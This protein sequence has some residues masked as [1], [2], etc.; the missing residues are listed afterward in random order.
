MSVF[1]QHELATQISDFI[2]SRGPPDERKKVV[3]ACATAMM[4]HRFEIDVEDGKI[5]G[6]DSSWEDRAWQWY[7]CSCGAFH[8]NP[9]DRMAVVRDI[10][11]NI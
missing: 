2:V 11:K 7:V 1:N 6:T 4:N 8:T 10:E 5:K 9:I 3:D